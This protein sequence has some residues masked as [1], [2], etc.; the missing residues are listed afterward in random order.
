MLEHGGRVRAAAAQWGIPVGE[1]L[2]LSTGIAPVGY[3]VPA[4]SADSW[5]RLPED[6]D[7]LE[8]AAGVYYG[9][10]HLLALPGSQ[11]A[12]QA[13]P[14]LRPRSAVAV[15]AP[16]YGEHAAAWQA[17]GHAL[18][19]FAADELGAVAEAAEVVVLVNPN[20][21]TGARFDRAQL[22]D[23]ARVLHDRG[24]WLVVDEAFADA[25]PA[26]ALA[27]VAGG[28][29]AP[30]LVVLR[31]L[32]KFFGLAG[33]RVGFAVA[34]PP[35]LKRL[36]VAVGPWA[37]AHPAREVARAALADAAWQA[38]QREQ[39][40]A[41]SIRLARMI[42]AAGLGESA[43]TALFRYVVTPRA[44][45]IFNALARHGI[46]LR[47]FDAPAALRFGLPGSEAEWQRL[48]A[49]LAEAVL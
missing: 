44:E 33:A 29:A 28:A 48:A 49:A 14:R 42:A 1:W 26:Q 35:L 7:G 27:D 32:G 19:P 45:A 5:R 23:A 13:L 18:R 41:A 2:D 9:A 36:A 20:N 4:L 38:R 43:G 40:R 46:L 47:R 25:D 3:P 15:L 11:A 24:G 8:A 37:I 22:L 21:P 10:P 17:A 31:S 16:G 6:E 30:N 12:I 34:A 39:L